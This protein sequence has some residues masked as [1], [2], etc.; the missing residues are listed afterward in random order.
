MSTDLFLRDAE[1]PDADAVARIHVRTWQQAYRGLLPDAYLDSMRA[2]DRARRYTFGLGDPASPRTIVALAQGELVGFATL[3]AMSDEANSATR[4]PTLVGELCALHVDPE[5]WGR[6]IGLALI[7]AARARMSA[8]GLRSARL[9]LLAGNTRAAR[10]YQ[11]DGWVE[12]GERRTEVV[13]GASVDEIGL[14]RG[15]P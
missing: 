3:R 7:R 11:L 2:E 5:H 10:F 1:P 9:W 14:R 15:L 13:W 6:R 8:Y 4:V 12:D